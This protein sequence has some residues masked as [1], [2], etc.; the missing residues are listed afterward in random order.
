MVVHAFSFNQSTREAEASLVYQV[1]ARRVRAVQKKLLSRKKMGVGAKRV[2]MS[3][4]LILVRSGYALM[5]NKRRICQAPQHIPITLL[6]LPVKHC[7]SSIKSSHLSRPLKSRTQQSWGGT[8]CTGGLPA[9]HVPQRRTCCHRLVVL[10][11]HN[12]QTIQIL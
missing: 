1:S 7:T 3:K 9:G 8:D 12:P 11:P 2:Q 4:K 10:R 6:L 5:R